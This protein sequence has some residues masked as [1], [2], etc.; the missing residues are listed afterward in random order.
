MNKKRLK[1]EKLKWQIKNEIK[2]IENKKRTSTWKQMNEEKR[3]TKVRKRQIKNE[4][5]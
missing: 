3:K 1:T 2:T 5:L 4:K